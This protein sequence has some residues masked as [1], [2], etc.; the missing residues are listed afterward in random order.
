MSAVSSPGTP[1]KADKTYDGSVDFLF[2]FPTI[3]EKYFLF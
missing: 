1:R 2:I 3:F